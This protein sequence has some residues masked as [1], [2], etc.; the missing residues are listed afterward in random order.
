MFKELYKYR[1]L[2]YMLTLRDIKIRYKQA[3]M[4]FMWA[5]FMPVMAV[6]AGVL[7]QEAIAMVSGKPLETK[8]IVSI[9][10]K[11]LP[12]TFFTNSIRFAMQ[13]LV[14]NMGLVTKV[15]FPREVLPLSSILACMFD[16]IIGVFTL[17][18]LLAFA[19]VGASIYLALVPFLL[20]L[21]LLF[22]TGI[23][24]LLAS[25]NLFFRDVRYV[26]EIILMFGIFFTPVFFKASTFGK[27]QTLFLLNPVGSILESISDAVVAQTMPPLPWML[28]AAACSLLFFFVGTLVFRRTEPSF[29]E[30]I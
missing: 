2:L 9:S 18:A 5:I 16:F 6:A 3:V 24:L 10:V 1:D 15:Y 23:G 12:W 7:V 17:T 8:G 21:L 4:G 13:S 14:G 29:A 27:W 28:Y 11:V 19:G 22:T 26:V 30:N 25:A 20:L